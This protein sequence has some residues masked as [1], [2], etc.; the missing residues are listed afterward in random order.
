MAV[1]LKNRM[2]ITHLISQKFNVSMSE[3]K[4][5]M[6]QKSVWATINATLVNKPLNLSVRMEDPNHDMDA[7]PKPWLLEVGKKRKALIE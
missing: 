3:A 1:P 2:K 4:R 7:V 6:V 5:L